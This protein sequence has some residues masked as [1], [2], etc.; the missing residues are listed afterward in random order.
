MNVAIIL[1]AGVGQRMRNGGLPKQFLKLMGKPIIIYTLEKFE[2]SE[3]I[4]RIIVVCHGSYI[5]YMQELLHLYQIRKVTDVIVGGGDRQNSLRRG[6]AAVV[7]NGGT[8]EDLV[9]IHDGV[10]PLIDLPTIRENV[11]VA[12]QYGCAITVHPVTETVVITEVEE[13]GIENFKKRA[14]TYSMTAPQTFRLGEILSAYQKID[15]LETAD[16]PLLDAA[17]VFAQAGGE[18]HLVKQQGA[19]IKI[20]TPEDYYFLKAMLE[21]EENK[22]VFGL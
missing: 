14:D 7:E 8:S 4:D 22:F 19:N 6:L 20:T 3:A 13:A 12:S 15:S 2:E 10:R 9:I 17:M 16:M 21:L 1:A 18:V 5:D 11:R